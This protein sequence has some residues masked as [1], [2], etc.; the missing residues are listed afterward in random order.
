MGKKIA[1][2]SALGG[3]GCTSAAAYVGSAMAESGKIVAMLDLCGFG[4]TL[5]H[6]MG[7][8]ED[9]AMN[10]GDVVC[11]VCS[12]EEALVSCEMPGLSLMPPSSFSEG[13]IYPYS[14]KYRQIVESMSREGDVIADIPSGVLPD[15]DAV[16]CFDM[17]VVCTSADRLSL[18]YA[19]ALCRAIRSTASECG[20]MCEIRFLLTSF[21]PEDMRAG[22]IGDIDECIDKAG[23][24]LLGIIPRDRAV[25]R[26]VVD[27]RA[28]DA[29]SEAMQYS[30]DIAGRICGEIVPLEPKKSMFR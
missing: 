3:Q 16:S 1:M 7:V 8:A 14:E 17:F 13:N 21:S 27:G 5:A 26:A 10:V 30:R 18:Q 25:M 22:G 24:R 11:G 15:C 19:A 6:V 2:I 20:A 4:G 12:C 23:A 29:L 9:A 28:P